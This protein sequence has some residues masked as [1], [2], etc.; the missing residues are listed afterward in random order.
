MVFSVRTRK[1]SQQSSVS[2]LE[3]NAVWDLLTAT[4]SAIERSEIWDAFAHDIDLAARLKAFRTHLLDIARTLENLSKQY[5]LKGPDG[6]R[7]GM[8]SSTSSD[9]IHDEQIAVWLL[10]DNQERLELFFT[11]A[12]NSIANDHLRAVLMAEI[13]WQVEYLDGLIKYVKL[14]GWIG[15]PPFYPNVPKDTNEKIDTSEA[16]HI[17]DRLTFVYDFTGLVNMFATLA[18]DGDLQAILNLQL[19]SLKGQARI[20]EREA[21]KFGLPLPKPPAKVPAQFENKEWLDDNFIFRRLLNLAH[22]SSL[23]HIA[24]FRESM[25]NDRVRG[26]FRNMLLDALS[27]GDRLIVYGKAKGWLNEPPMYRL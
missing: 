25:T 6:P 21:L 16:Y 3:A 20:L 17:W 27:A 11:S 2:V 12:V 15:Q 7:R 5:S 19:D 13:R 22:G 4:Y 9:A 14:K 1:R 23:I 26:I 10:T 24:A 18:Y 8:N